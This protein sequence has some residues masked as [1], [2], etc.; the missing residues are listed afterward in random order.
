MPIRDKQYSKALVVDR[1]GLDPIMFSLANKHLTSNTVSDFI[2]DAGI[3]CYFSD[4]CRNEFLYQYN[5]QQSLFSEPLNMNKITDSI[6][7]SDAGALSSS[8][9]NINQLGIFASQ[10]EISNSIQPTLWQNSPHYKYL[11]VEDKC[12]IQTPQ[13]LR[14][15]YSWVAV[16][17]N[18]WHLREQCI[19]YEGIY[20]YGTCSMLAGMVITDVISYQKGSFIYY[21]WLNQNPRWI[22][23]E[24]ITRRKLKFKEVLDIE[25]ERVNNGKSFWDS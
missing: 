1:S 6:Y 25:R 20:A 5:P 23:S 10:S 17:S 24:K 8:S 18:D 19:S 12:I 4:F 16:F 22:P 9:F 2:N 14:S 3:D 13:Q 21:E 11:S 15:E 7:L